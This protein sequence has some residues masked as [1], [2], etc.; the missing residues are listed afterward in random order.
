MAEQ[1]VTQGFWSPPF[2]FFLY[3][4][5][6]TL[7][8]KLR[9][10]RTPEMLLYSSWNIGIPAEITIFW[11][12]H[13]YSNFP[14]QFETCAYF[15]ICTYALLMQSWAGMLLC[16]LFACTVPRQPSSP[17]HVMSHTS[18]WDRQEWQVMTNKH[19]LPQQNWLFN[20]DAIYP[21]A[22]CNWL[23]DCVKTSVEWPCCNIAQHTE[24]SPAG[25]KM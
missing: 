2:F 17:S 22:A 20:E 6:G 11:N 16:T 1:H 3:N 21:L 18:S 23:V 15:F 4:L 5:G 10:W 9:S 12:G 19:L 8:K 7:G 24:C 14:I 25:I 13:K